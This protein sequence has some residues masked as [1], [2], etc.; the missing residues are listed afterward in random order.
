[1]RT[2]REPL[3]SSRVGVQKQCKKMERLTGLNTE[4]N[5]R[6][7][8]KSHAG[9]TSAF[10]SK[11]TISARHEVFSKTQEHTVGP[12]CSEIQS[13]CAER[14]Y[15]NNNNNNNKFI[16]IWRI[17]HTSLCALQTNC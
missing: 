2:G 1:M 13:Q 8:I 5:T 17:K 9:Q 16:L 12:Q 7:N 10:L 15:N 4:V 6:V 14:S 3:H 11:T